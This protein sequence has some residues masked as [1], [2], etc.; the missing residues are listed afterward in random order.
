ME[1]GATFMLLKSEAGRKTNI[2]ER[3]YG[4]IILEALEVMTDSLEIGAVTLSAGGDSK[5][6][7]Y[8]GDGTIELDPRKFNPFSEELAVYNECYIGHAP[9][10]SKAGARVT[11]N[12]KVN[13]HEN[14]IR[15]TPEE[16]EAELSVIKIKP[17]K[18]PFDTPVNVKVEEIIIEYFNGIGWKKLE[19]DTEYAGLFEGLENGD[20]K[21]SFICPSDWVQTESGPYSG[22]CLR[23][24][25]TKASN[26]YMRPSIHNYPTIENLKISYS[27]EGKFI[28]PKKIEAIAG[29]KKR[30]LTANLTSD[31]PYTVLSGI[32]YHEDALYIGLDRKLTDGPVSIYFQLSD[33]NNQNGV[34]VRL[35]YMGA[36]GFTEMR[37]TDLTEDFTRS[38]TLMFMPP[39]D[40]TESVFEGNRLYF[41]RLVR[42]RTQS[43]QVE[44][45]FLPKIVKL[46]LNAV[47]VINVQTSDE[48]DY[49]IEEVLPN[50]SIALGA[51][52]IL[53]A[54]VW[55]NEKGFTR[56]EE[57]DELLEQHPEMVRAEY[58]FLGRISA[59]YVLWHEVEN[60]AVATD[61]RCYRIDR[62]TGRI[63]FSDGTDCDMPRVTDDIA[64]KARVRSTDGE[65]G[66]V[67]EGEI[68]GFMGASP[69]ISSVYNPIRSHG[70][71][72]LETLDH[73]LM[74][75]AGIMNSRYRL[76]S[77][78]DYIRYCLEYSDSIDKAKIVTEETIEGRRNP[79]DISIVLLMK[80][81]ADGAF[82]FHRLAAPLQRDILKRCEL[83]IPEENLHIIEPIFVEI[84]VSV[85]A[86][87]M[88]MDD[89]FEVQNEVKSVLSEFLDPVSTE[90]SD[91]WDIG[92]LPKESQILMRLGF[93]RSKAVIQRVTMI[94]RYMDASGL[95]EIDTK[96]IEISP[97]MVVRSGEHKVYITNK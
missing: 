70:G 36:N 49:Y 93:L 89:S 34:K 52:H 41:L 1:D 6:A 94:G 31:K 67:G 54:V 51:E 13:Y 84:S 40:M 18:T 87:V 4:V 90:H 35:E 29:T 59:F 96:E 28:T 61:R 57:M 11:L 20:Y 19:C 2:G 23:M 95:H 33:N 66:N 30:D 56:K 75:C 91:G 85:W 45:I 22:K 16:E 82:S 3:K 47:T 64:F 71:S 79:A 14:L 74:R 37:I 39:S 92:V 7:E 10:F 8:V 21:L 9:C 42:S 55:V 15:L 83:T 46:C 97:F 65:N 88:D 58:D 43:D 73:A 44:D 26:C 72:N 69:Y 48:R 77:E 60:F 86:M 25:I 5:A 80:D 62:M 53:D 50:A 12:F 81:Y 38:G 24:R 68:S 76:V 78:N 32:D 17:K 63:I 27:Y